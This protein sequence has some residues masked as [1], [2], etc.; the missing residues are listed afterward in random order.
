[1]NFVLIALF[2]ST[3][4][5]LIKLKVTNLT[6]QEL[7]TVNGKFNLPDGIA[8]SSNDFEGF[9]LKFV[10]VDN[11]VVYPA[12]VNPNGTYSIA[13]PVGRYRRVVASKAFRPHT[14]YVCVKSSPSTNPNKNSI[15]LIPLQPPVE[16]FTL[17]GL[18]KDATTDKLIPNSIL[19]SSVTIKFVNKVT[20]NVYQVTFTNSIYEVKLP[21]GTYTREVTGAS[22]AEMKDDII[23][24]GDSNETE[25]HN[26]I[27]LSPIFKGVRA[28]LVWD[29]LPQDLDAHVILP[30][31]FEVNFT[32][33]SSD[34]GHVTLDVDNL[35]GYGPE[36]VSMK[37]LAPGV[38]KY[39]VNRFS[40]EAPLSQSNAKV[41]IFNANQL[42][43]EI[44]V[45]TTNDTYENWHVFN[46]DAATNTLELVNQLKE[47]M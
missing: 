7:I 25:K 29:K 8:F 5:N 2:L 47:S 33:K 36:T 34:D 3:S 43:G 9:T 17:R 1:L 23:I 44:S 14:S 35:K 6:K 13:V 20:K 10:K 40:N 26:I 38:Y 15:N 37:D 22:Y 41:K 31:G 30:S 16:L 28:V 45:P 4:V 18:V 46:Y 21:K 42:Y 12:T 24:L 39:Y 19:T 11:G 27:F 32:K